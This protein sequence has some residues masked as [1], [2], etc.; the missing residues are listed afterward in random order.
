VLKTQEAQGSAASASTT[1]SEKSA[2]QWPP[3]GVDWYY[4]DESCAIACGD[5]REILPLLP[6]HFQYLTR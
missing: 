2:P 6:Q 4:V 3:K 1:T 5:C